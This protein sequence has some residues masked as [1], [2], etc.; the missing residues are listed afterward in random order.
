MP[1]KNFDCSKCGGSHSRPINSKCKL[2]GQ[3]SNVNEASAFPMDTNTL[4]LQELKSLSGRMAE[5]ERKVDGTVHSPASSVASSSKAP[6]P[7]EDSEEEEEDELILPSIKSLQQS[8]RMQAQVDQRIQQLKDLNE[9][10]KF[11]SQRGGKDT[12]WVKKE[13]PW[14]QNFI[15]GG[16]ANKNRVTYDALSMSQ[17]VSGFAQIVREESDNIVKNHMLEYLA[18]LMEDSHDFG[19]QSAKGSHA[20]LLCRMEDNKIQWQDTHKID[21]LRRVHAQRMAPTPQNKRIN[22]KGPLVC[23]FY[24]KGGCMQKGDHEN[25]GQMY[26]HVCQHC[27][28][29]GKSYPHPGKDC[30]NR[31]KNDLGTA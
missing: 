21:R 1:R 25:N 27:Y 14:P 11:K 29:Q 13:V 10:G 17:W 6:T 12:V 7:A 2:E 26:L 20:V 8:K 23:K 30:K 24:Q 3:N 19:W 28:A 18:E 22:V 16:G 9:Q 31:S 5:M 15:L 4:I